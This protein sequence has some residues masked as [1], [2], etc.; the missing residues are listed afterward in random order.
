ML[1]VRV[2]DVAPLRGLFG[3]HVADIRGHAVDGGVF[4]GLAVGLGAA[5]LIGLR[6][7]AQRQLRVVAQGYIVVPGERFVPPRGF[8]EFVHVRDDRKAQNQEHVRPEVGD[9]I[10]TYR[11]TPEISA[12]TMI[13]VETESTIPS[14]IRNERILCARSVS[15]ATPIGSRNGTRRFINT[16]PC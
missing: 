6:A 14:S 5:Q 16:A 10:G 1:I 12:T 13:S 4:D 9:A 7:D 3:L 11:F 8:H 2:R 15:S